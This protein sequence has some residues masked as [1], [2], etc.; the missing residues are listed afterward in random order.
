MGDARKYGFVSGGGGRRWSKPFEQLFPGARVFVLV[1]K[2]GYVAVGTVTEETK[3][4]RDFAV[5]IDGRTLPLLEA[6]LA[7]P[8]IGE[9][10]DDEE[11]SEY[12][13]RVEWLEARPKEQA[14]WGKGLIRTPAHRAPDA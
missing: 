11:R 5:Q 13:V 12:L 7:A 4:I 14:L 10:A 3:R 1:P 2:S 9:N 8:R 6:P